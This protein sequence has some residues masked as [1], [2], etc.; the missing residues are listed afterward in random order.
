[1]RTVDLIQRK[2]DGEELAPEEIEYLVEGY[3]RGDIPDYQMSAFLMAVYFSSMTDREVSRLTECMLRSGDTV[4]LSQVPGIKVDKHSTGGVGDKTS[5][6]VAPLA[7]AA[8]VA[9]PMMS[10]RGLGHT[11]GTLD[12]L[13]SIP[14]FRTDFTPDEFRK[15]LSE[16]GLAF[17]GQ[18]D[19]L[20]PADRKFYALRDVT[21]TVESIPL[22]S[23]SIM[24]KKLAEGIDSLVLDVKVGN[25]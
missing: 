10:G 17:I 24:S 12:K 15:Q 16:L 22:I 8:G 20:A 18:S 11:G 5:F 9:V 1:M 13:E 2:R 23:S 25:G 19:H 14:G 4:D 3:T 21:G 6:I 7:A